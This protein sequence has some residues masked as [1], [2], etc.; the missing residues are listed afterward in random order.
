MVQPRHVVCALGSWKTFA[1]IEMV[2]TERGGPGF[3]IDLKYSQLEPDPR[4]A[5]AFAVAADRVN[6]SITDADRAAIRDHTAVAYILSPSI[7]PGQGQTVSR[8]MLALIGMLIDIGATAIKS[9]S[10]GVAHGLERW[11]ELATTAVGG[12][13]FERAV[14]LRRAWVRRPITDGDTLYTCGMHLLGDRDIEIPDS[15]DVRTDVHW[16]DFFATF[17]LVEKP[18]G[19]PDG[20]SFRQTEDG[21]VRILRARECTRY[22][23]DDYLHN[24]YGYWRLESAQGSE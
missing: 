14:A 23:S 21:E 2:L 9:R 19:M 24:P 6:P 1:P 8:H 15:G 12:S 5:D 4:M 13:E 3:V 22:P 17:L 18:E 7:E 20:A 10:A 16:L 11:R